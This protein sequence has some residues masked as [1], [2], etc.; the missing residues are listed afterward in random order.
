MYYKRICFTI[1]LIILVLV[2]TACVRLSS[3]PVRQEGKFSKTDQSLIELNYTAKAKEVCLVT[4]I[5]E[6]TDGAVQCEIV[7][8]DNKQVFSGNVVYENGKLYSEVLYSQN[9]SGQ[10]LNT[11]REVK[12]EVDSKG[13]TFVYPSFGG[14]SL[15]EGEASGKYTLYLRPQNAEGSYKVDWSDRFPRK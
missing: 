1:P 2:M 12:T 15:N 11:K 13:N 8:S 5:F 10:A 4:V 3:N 7:D 6:L 9:Q 14:Y